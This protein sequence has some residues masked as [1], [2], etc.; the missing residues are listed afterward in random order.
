MSIMAIS[1]TVPR[2]LLGLFVIGPLVDRLSRRIVLLTSLIFQAIC[3]IGIAIL[4]T[5]NLLEIWMLYLLGAL[6]AIAHEFVRTADYA[7]IPVM[8]GDRKMEAMAGL[9]AAFRLSLILGPVIASFLLAFTEYSTLL[10]INAVTYLGPVIMSIWI[11]IPHE[12][13]GGVRSVRQ[14]F[15]DLKDGLWFIRKSIGLVRIIVSIALTNLAIGGISTIIIFHMKHNYKLMDDTISWLLAL[16]SIGSFVSSLV[17]PKFKK[18][19]DRK[20]MILGLGV[21]SCSLLLLLMPVFWMIPMALVIMGLGNL[22]FIIAYNVKVQEATV[23]EMMGRVG[24]AVR[25]VEFLSNG[26]STALLGAVTVRYGVGT[27]LL[28]SFFLSLTPL[29]VVANRIKIVNEQKGQKQKSSS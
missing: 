24:S 1:E 2:S 15:I 18:I 27:S 12:N 25:M 19:S 13:L 16:R 14:V 28:V 20:M 23:N 7:V 22:L 5:T 29:L 21:T 11:R 4:N 6:I 26:I 17:A 10:W 3:S 8:F 9:Q